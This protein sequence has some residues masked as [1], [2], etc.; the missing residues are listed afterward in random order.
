MTESPLKNILV[1]GL[2]TETLSDVKKIE[3]KGA[4]I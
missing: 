2:E 4:R 3:K 1:F